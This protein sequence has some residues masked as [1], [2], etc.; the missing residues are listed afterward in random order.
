MSIFDEQGPF[1]RPDGAMDLSAL[2]GFSGGDLARD[3]EHRSESAV[4]DAL[5]DPAARLVLNVYDRIL[6]DM[7]GTPSAYFTRAD[8]ETHNADLSEAV[9]LG[10]KPEGWPVL[11]APV[12]APQ[13]I[14]G[15]NVVAGHLP[16][17]AGVTE[18]VKA[19]DLRSLAVQALLPAADMGTLALARALLFWHDTHRFCA[20]CGTPSRM[21]LGGF[22]RD[23]PACGASHFPRTDPVAI[24]LAVDGERC[25][26]GRQHRFAEGMYS[27]LAGFIEPGETFEDS[28]R[29]ETFEEAGIRLGRVVY[30]SCQP[31]PF[32]SSLMIGCLG[33]ALNTDIVRD[34]DELEDCRWF[35]RNEVRLMLARTHPDG[36]ICPPTMAIAHTL[37]RAFVDAD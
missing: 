15:P 8:A 24:M 2:N 5:A 9:L 25:L 18:T 30:H 6:V 31:W 14:D 32:P 34:D 22:R 7:A 11:A 4:A 17:A 36:L 28:V 10:H 21:A 13:D 35:T 29:R 33:E 26:L 27:C 23:C 1:V 19:I 12:P 37:I 16:A 20:R 3:A